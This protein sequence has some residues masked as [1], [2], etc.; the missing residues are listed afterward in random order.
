MEPL[1]EWFCKGVDVTSL[2]EYE[3]ALCQLDKDPPDIRQ[4]N[5]N[6]REERWTHFSLEGVKFPVATVD[7]SREARQWPS[8]RE[9]HHPFATDFKGRS[10]VCA[11]IIGRDE[12]HS[13]VRRSVDETTNGYP[14][15][16]PTTEEAWHAHVEGF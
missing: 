3:A 6:I 1:R 14:W 2:A 16:Q 4:C 13:E 11:S 5:D 15:S 10:L 12:T 8:L 7:V 9:T